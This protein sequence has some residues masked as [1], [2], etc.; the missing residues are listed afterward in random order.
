MANPKRGVTEKSMEK[1]RKLVK[2]IKDNPDIPLTHLCK[3]VGIASCLYREIKKESCPKCGAIYPDL[4]HM[5]WC[6]GD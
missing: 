4:P 2:L 1:Y 5:S 3:R 6:R